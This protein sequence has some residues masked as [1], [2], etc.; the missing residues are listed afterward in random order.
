MFGSRITDAVAY[1]ARRGE[2]RGAVRV[3]RSRRPDKFRWR[4]AVATLSQAAGKMHGIERMRIEEPV[5]EV[6]VD[7]DD[8]DLQQ[9]VVLDARRHRVDFDRGE[10]L[11][12]HRM[13]DLRRM[14]YVVGADIRL[15]QRHVR[16]PDDF[17]EPIDT[18]G[19]ALVSRA[20]GNHFR[21]RAEKLWLML[22]Q[23]Q[24][25]L[26]DAKQRAVLERARKEFDF[27]R[28]W[29]ALSRALLGQRPPAQ[30]ADPFSALGERLDGVQ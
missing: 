27:A 13:G 9:E 4:W 24:K 3:V 1:W 2:P 5:R 10:L 30:E 8:R 21:R 29:T 23:G 20:Y 18:A 25:P 28:R 7:L 6:V 12:Q 16:L 15:V 11:P 19:V 22:P 17:D 14:A 26:L